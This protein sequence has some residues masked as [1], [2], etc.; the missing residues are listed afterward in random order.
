MSYMKK[1][2]KMIMILLTMLYCTGT[3]CVVNAE[4]VRVYSV[5]GVERT[6]LSKANSTAP[7]IT[8]NKSKIT[9]NTNSSITLKATVI[10]KSKKATW[11]SSNNKIATVNLK[12]KVTA[13]KAGIVTI[14]AKANGISAKCIITVKNDTNTQI[15]PLS[16]FKGQ[17]FSYKDSDYQ[18]ELRISKKSQN[19]YL[20]MWNKSGRG[21]SLE[22]FSFSYVDNKYTYYE[23]GC[24]SYSMYR[25]SIV[26]QSK[27]TIQVK[28]SGK[29]VSVCGKFKYAGKINY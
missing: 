12:G 8:L 17:Y 28:I 19:I 23:K 15:I 26:P 20:G 7:K 14:T 24:R 29:Y 13:K 27:D 25:L 21:P 22:D 16:A 10:G 1:M 6:V 18:Y 5:N 4:D 9:L 2:C 3:Q 11:K